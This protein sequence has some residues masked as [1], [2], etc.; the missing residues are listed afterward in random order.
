MATGIDRE[1]IP[2]RS[3][4]ST[5]SIQVLCSHTRLLWLLAILLYVCGDVLTTALGMWYT[6]LQEASP[7]PRY[8]LAEFGVG[9]VAGLKMGVFGLFAVLWRV[10]PQPVSAGV[11]LGLALVGYAITLWNATM[12][13][14]VVT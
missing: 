8:L 7:L 5:A 3:N 6:P 11:P 4:R 12:I 1:R 2:D 13:V 14:L 9:A 10:L